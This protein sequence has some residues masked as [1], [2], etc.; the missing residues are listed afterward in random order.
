MPR[1]S[2]R[3]YDTRAE[4][5]LAA[6]AVMLLVSGF[7]AYLAAGPYHTAMKDNPTTTGLRTDDMPIGKP[8]LPAVFTPDP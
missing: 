2:T 3:L 6:I 4:W 8:A 7:V 1:F 5:L